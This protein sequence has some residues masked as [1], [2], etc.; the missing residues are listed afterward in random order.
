MDDGL[1][2]EDVLKGIIGSTSFSKPNVPE[3]KEIK[4]HEIYDNTYYIPNNKLRLLETPMNSSLT[5]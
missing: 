5:F 2:E 1:G 4:R 3:N